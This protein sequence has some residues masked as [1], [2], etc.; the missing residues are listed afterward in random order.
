MSDDEPAWYSPDRKPPAPRAPRPP[1][2][3]FWSIVVEH[4]AWT[5]EFRFCGE[6]YGWDVRLLRAG[7]FFGSRRFVLRAAAERW[8]N[9][10][11]QHIER[12]W[13]D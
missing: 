13:L 9:E 3:I 7:D 12:G 2:E 8:A 10:Q 5:C 4:V 1:D 11:K 6:D